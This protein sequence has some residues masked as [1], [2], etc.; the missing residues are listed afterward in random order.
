MKNP[1]NSNLVFGNFRLF[2]AADD[3]SLAGVDSA[4]LASVR[5]HGRAANRCAGFPL[6]HFSL[7]HDAPLVAAILDA[8]Q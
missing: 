1:H 4:D 5:A 3:G 6:Q 7:F 8:G 2:R